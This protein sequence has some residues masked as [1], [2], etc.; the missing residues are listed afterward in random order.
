MRKKLIT[1]LFG[2]FLVVLAAFHG[3]AAPSEKQKEIMAA[4]EKEGVLELVWGAGTI[5][6]ADGVKNL[7]S[8]FNKYYGLNLKVNF[9][10]GPAMPALAA[11]VAQEFS[12]GRPSQV[13]VFLGAD[14]HFYT[15]LNAKALEPLD[16]SGIFGIPA[17]V[18]L[19]EGIGVEIAT[20][21]PGVTYNTKLV[22]PKEIPDTMAGFLEP[23]WKG[24]LAST[25]YAANF[26][27]LSAP[28]LW[29]AAKTVDYVT[30]LSSQISGLIRCNELERIISGEF[31]AYVLDC[32]GYKV[33]KLKASGAPLA[34]VVLKD[35]ALIVYWNM[36]V[37]K[38]AKHPNA[39]KLFVNFMVSQPGQDLLYHLE[40]LDHM[41]LE[42]SRLLKLLLDN[43]VD[44][45]KMHDVGV[46]FLM[47][48]G[49]GLNNIR[50]QLQ[51]IL[52][53][54]PSS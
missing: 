36:G 1:G 37:P 35:A 26:D 19:P 32:G 4:A 11:K 42:G 13:D 10:P 51:G 3:W 31:K 30:R 46:K 40:Y 20:R 18:V 12:A 48:Q 45:D 49:T 28:E 39:A 27:H 2:C 53:K 52:K 8:A 6:G 7:E 50:R 15:L 5:G 44:V 17:R 24:A 41:R 14:E 22:S 21:V 9:T 38:T 25:P 43:G 23:R 34:Q 29:G 47:K 33:R 16:W 54:G